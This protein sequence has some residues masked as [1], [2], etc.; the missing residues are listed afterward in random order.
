VFAFGIGSGASTALVKGVARAG[1]GKAEFAE[2][3][4]Q[5]HSKVLTGPT[6]TFQ[7][8]PKK[9]FARYDPSG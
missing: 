8:F 5:L 9:L 1:K 7:K 3:S 2:N 6:K 4:S